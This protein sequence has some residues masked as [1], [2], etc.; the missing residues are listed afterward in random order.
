MTTTEQRWSERV[1]AWRASGLTAP[2]FCAGRDFTPGGLRHW[3]HVLKKRGLAPRPPASAVRLVRVDRVATASV[4]A[5]ED[6]A[7][8]T[9]ELG[10]ARVRVPR[11]ADRATVE[12]VL[13][14]LLRQG[15]GGAR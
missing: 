6:D 12:V 1:S 15:R 11:G 7:A 10:P 3:A 13:G 5:P 4:P 2:Q 8:L 14:A 9:V